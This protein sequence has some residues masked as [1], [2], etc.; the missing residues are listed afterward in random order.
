MNAFFPIYFSNFLNPATDGTL[1]AAV[2]KYRERGFSMVKLL[3]ITEKEPKFIREEKYQFEE[4]WRDEDEEEF[5][6]S[7]VHLL[8]YFHEEIDN[9]KQLSL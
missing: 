9:A 1:E 2:R 3:K 5:E 6:N 7:G 4:E 8:K